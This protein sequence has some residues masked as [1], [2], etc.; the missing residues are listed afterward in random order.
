MDPPHQRHSKAGPDL[1]ILSG[2][3]AL[4]EIRKSV[5]KIIL[6]SSEVFFHKRG[7]G[8]Q[9]RVGKQEW[10]SGGSFTRIPCRASERNLSDS[11]C[12]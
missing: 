5:T 6:D 1:S 7:A 4:T 11:S 10:L 2:N 9:S 8:L 3:T 12:L